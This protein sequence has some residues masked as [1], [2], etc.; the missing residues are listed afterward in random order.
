MGAQY[1]RAKSVREGCVD[2]S[3]ASYDPACYY[4]GETATIYEPGHLYVGFQWL[5]EDEFAAIE[6]LTIKGKFNN[7]DAF[8]TA[9][10]DLISEQIPSYPLN[11]PGNYRLVPTTVAV[12]QSDNI[13]VLNTAPDTGGYPEGSVF[14]PG[15]RDVRPFEAYLEMADQS[16]MSAPVRMSQ[17]GGALSGLAMPALKATAGKPYCQNGVLYIP[18][19][20]D[21]NAVVYSASG[22][23]VRSVAL[24]PGITEVHGLPAGL[25]LVG[26]NKVVVR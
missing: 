26:N 19:V 23:A 21:G 10:V 24:T 17:L 7:A 13:A 20:A 9:G 25:Y 2:N 1:I 4:D 5:S 18:A 22:I 3:V 16:R 14:I 15:L 11:A 6:S 8:L 12:A